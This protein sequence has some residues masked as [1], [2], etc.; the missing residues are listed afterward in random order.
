MHG[1]FLSI[2]SVGS[3]YQFG[4]VTIEPFSHIVLARNGDTYPGSIHLGEVNALDNSGDMITLRNNWYLIV[5]RVTYNDGQNCDESCGQCWP[6]NADAGGST[7]E[8][9]NPDFD[10]N[11][12]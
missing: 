5:D 9:I 3:C 6:S 1:W 4:D 11:N 2:N 8:L 7:L 12:A 10:N